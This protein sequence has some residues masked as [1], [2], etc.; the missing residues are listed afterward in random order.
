MLL[1]AVDLVKNKNTT[2]YV[3]EKQLGIPRR[4]IEK[5]VKK[6]RAEKTLEEFRD[7]FKNLE[8]SVQ[9]LSPKIL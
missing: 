2:S 7:Y 3:A 8:I 6:A 5:R 1:L 4:T 9:N